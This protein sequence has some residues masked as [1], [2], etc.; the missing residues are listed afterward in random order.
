MKQ[1]NELN[2]QVFFL[3]GQEVLVLIENKLMS[4]QL[5]GSHL[6]ATVQA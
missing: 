4:G 2:N 5:N 1:E 6:L 3:N